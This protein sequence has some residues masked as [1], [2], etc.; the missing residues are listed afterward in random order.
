MRT[1]R[2]IMVPALVVLA[3]VVAG[4]G[5]TN[6]STGGGTGTTP[7]TPTGPTAMP[8]TITRTGGIA[9]VSEKIDITA[10]GSWVFTDTKMNR[11]ERGNLTPA[12]RLGL[13]QLVGDP[14]FAEQLVQKNDPGVCSDTFRYTIKVGDVSASF[15]DDCGDTKRPAVDAVIK[16]ISDATPL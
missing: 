13:L 5:A 6:G 9:G 3:A 1:P 11:T 7:T 12:Q 4:C 16:A 10:D 14:R 2:W 8:V 15:E